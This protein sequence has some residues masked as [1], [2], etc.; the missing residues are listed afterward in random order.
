M[1]HPFA[2]SS[3]LAREYGP[4]VSHEFPALYASTAGACMIAGGI[5]ERVVSGLRM[6]STQAITSTHPPPL[7]G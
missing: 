3:G 5:G 2:A 7:A 1:I 4:N 6:L